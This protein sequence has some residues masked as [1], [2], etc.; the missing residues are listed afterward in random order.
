MQND[1]AAIRQVVLDWIA[2]TKAGDTDKVLSLMSDDVVFLMPGRP[3]MIGKEAFA[4]AAKAGAAAGVEFE[5]VSQVREV[6]V[7]GVW[8]YLWSELSVTVRPKNGAEVKRSGPVLSVLHKENGRW[9][10]H[11]DANMLSVVA[12]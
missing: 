5:G 1:E 4:T 2:A 6:K 12:N 3:P 9:V 11:R 7:F 10:I 8:A